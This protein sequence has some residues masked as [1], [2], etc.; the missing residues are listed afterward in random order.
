MVIIL[1][2]VVVGNSYNCTSP[3]HNAMQDGINGAQLC[4]N[5]FAALCP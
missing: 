5:M 4:Y 1:L 2:R 3:T